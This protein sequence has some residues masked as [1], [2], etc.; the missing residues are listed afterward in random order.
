MR[1]FSSMLSSEVPGEPKDATG[2]EGRYNITLH[3][4]RQSLASNGE[5]SSDV[6]IF[7]ALREQLG[8]ELTKGTEPVSVVVIDRLDRPDGN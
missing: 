1:Q 8:L 3:W 6:D 2:L 5:A 4:S 7:K